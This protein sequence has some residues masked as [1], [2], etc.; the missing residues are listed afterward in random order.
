MLRDRKGWCLQGN[1]SADVH[2]HVIHQVAKL[3]A[4]HSEAEFP[5]HPT[6]VGTRIGFFGMLKN[7]TKQTNKQQLNQFLTETYNLYMADVLPQ[8]SYH[9][10]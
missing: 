6:D 3:Q 7:K 4:M 1:I 10:P 5:S 8:T 2:F 9:P